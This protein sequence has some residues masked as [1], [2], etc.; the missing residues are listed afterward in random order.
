[1]YGELVGEH[2]QS[3][4][5]DELLNLYFASFREFT[6]FIISDTNSNS[7]HLRGV[8]LSGADFRGSKFYINNFNGVILRFC[9]FS[10]LDLSRTC[11]IEADLAGANLS[12]ACLWRVLFDDANL[13]GADLSES[14]L[15]EARFLRSN[16]YRVNFADARL[17]DTEF[18]EANLTGAYLGG[19]DLLGGRFRNTIMP[20]GSIKND[21]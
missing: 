9:N 11:F 21:V 3:I 17:L 8:D 18:Q 7:S 2:T 13:R 4:T 15:Q 5:F 12:G 14:D 20:N 6:N 10:N 1:M 16:L 19:V